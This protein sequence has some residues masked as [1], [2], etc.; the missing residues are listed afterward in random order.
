MLFK[1]DYL[2]VSG[3]F[4]LREAVSQYHTLKNN[5]QYKPDNILISPGSKEL[6]FQCQMVIKSS[7][8]LPSPSWV[9]YEPQARFLNKK[10]IG[11]KLQK[12]A[13]GT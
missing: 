13:I 5:Y 11:L 3:L 6:L 12:I 1:K 9:S 2:N 10:S 7:L 8:I 4:E